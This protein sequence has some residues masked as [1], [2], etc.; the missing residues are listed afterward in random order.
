MFFESVT[1]SVPSEI[2][3]DLYF[4]TNINVN[5]LVSTQPTAMS[6]LAFD[7][8]DFM[9]DRYRTSTVFR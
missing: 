1:L 7:Q 6:L 8:S 9:I 3:I 2:K 4:D 5:M